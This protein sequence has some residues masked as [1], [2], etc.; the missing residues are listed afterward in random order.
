MTALT[1]QLMAG[2]VL[3]SS[4]W[5]IT[6]TEIASKSFYFLSFASKKSTIVVFVNESGSIGNGLC[7]NHTH[8]IIHVVGQIGSLSRANLAKS[9]PANVRSQFSGQLEGLLLSTTL[10]C[11]M[12]VP[13]VSRY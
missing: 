12:P 6:L 7:V 1:I 4:V 11:L 8:R 3:G 2:E 13:R 5:P 10:S 9:S